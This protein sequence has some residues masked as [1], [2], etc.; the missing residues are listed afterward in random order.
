MAMSNYSTLSLS[1]SGEI[2]E[3]KWCNDRR[4]VA[5]KF[6][7]YFLIFALFNKHSFLQHLSFQN[8]SLLCFQSDKSYCWNWPIFFKKKSRSPYG[9]GPRH[10]NQADSMCFLMPFLKDTELISFF[11]WNEF[12]CKVQLVWLDLATFCHFG[13]MLKVVGQFLEGLFSIW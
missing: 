10:K 7:N 13:K 12:W 9:V 1:L 11:F 2:S 6:Q 8:S 3:S 4:Q 5:L